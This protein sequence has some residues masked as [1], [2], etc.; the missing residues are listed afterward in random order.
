M[1][2]GTRRE[3]LS[4]LCHKDVRIRHRAF[5]GGKL[6]FSLQGRM[7]AEQ[8]SRELAAFPCPLARY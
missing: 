6:L 3:S 8:I 7:Q 2:Q 1:Q 5:R 4:K